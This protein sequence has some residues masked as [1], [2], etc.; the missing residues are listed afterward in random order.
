MTPAFDS[1]NG[2]LDA[3]LEFDELEP[4]SRSANSGLVGADLL[5]GRL[6]VLLEHV[7]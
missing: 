1:L 5:T 6:Q 7:P 4:R 3:L 2:P